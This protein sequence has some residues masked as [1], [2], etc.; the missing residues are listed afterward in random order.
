MRTVASDTVLSVSPVRRRGGMLAPLSP[1]RRIDEEVERRTKPAKHVRHYLLGK[2]LGRGSYGTV[3]EAIDDRTKERVAMKIVKRAK[4]RKIPGGLRAV[5]HEAKIN[6]LL[7]HENVVQ[8]LDHFV[9]EEKDKIYMALEYVSGGSVADLVKEYPQGLL[10]RYSKPLFRQLVEGLQYIHSMHVVHGDIKPGNLLLC[11]DTGVVKITDFGVSCVLAGHDLGDLDDGFVEGGSSLLSA[12]HTAQGSVAFQ[13]PELAS[14]DLT[15]AEC[16]FATDNWAAGIVLFVVA[17]GEYPFK[18][19]SVVEMLDNIVDCNFSIP[20]DRLSEELA[21]LLSLMLCKD[22]QQRPSLEKV[23]LHPWL[24]EA[25]PVGNHVLV[26][27]RRVSVDLQRPSIS[28]GDSVG[29]GGVLQEEDELSSSVSSQASLLSSSPAVSTPHSLAQEIP[30]A[31][32]DAV[33]P[34]PEE[35][36]PRL[37][38]QVN[39]AIS[40]S[41]SRLGS[42]KIKRTPTGFVQA[43][44][45]KFRVDSSSVDADLDDEDDLDDEEDDEEDLDDASSSEKLSSSSGDGRKPHGGLPPPSRGGAGGVC[46]CSLL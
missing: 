11:A 29:G 37:A 44:N 22:P 46:G 21:D 26:V 8:M 34:S 45:G 30:M 2:V 20:R 27:T 9:V 3:C 15:M 5:F 25:D 36:D 1:V 14:G 28:Q 23:L 32:D 18:G 40:K 43:D 41:P 10:E 35:M 13:P 6:L 16:G 33:L 7:E 4:A 31:G 38:D 42:L 24:Q 39:K 12:N 17:T 19:S